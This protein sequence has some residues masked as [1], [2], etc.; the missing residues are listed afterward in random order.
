MNVLV[1]SD[2]PLMLKVGKPIFERRQDVKYCFTDSDAKNPKLDH[3]HIVK[4]F[5]L[6]ISLHCK[7]IFPKELYSKVRCVNIHPGY[8]PYNR[9]IYPHV[10]SII[11]KYPA[12]ATIHEIDGTIDAGPIIARSEVIPSHNDTSQTLYYKVFVEELRLLRV[13]LDMIIDGTYQT[14]PCSFEG[15]YNSMEDFK[16]L[17]DID[18]SKVGRFQEFYD[19]MR[20]LS[21]GKFKN[22]HIGETYF[23]MQI[24]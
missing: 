24:L 14:F 1:L 20:A 16:K 5:D 2:N 3:K 11:N 23:K 7:K 22:A 6:V 18:P 10:W 8:N 9:G 17:C 21:F 19:L 12:G 15:N 4:E 13:H